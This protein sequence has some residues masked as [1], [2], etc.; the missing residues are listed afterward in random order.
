MTAMR[1][2]AYLFPAFPVLHQT[3]TLFEVVGL[4]RRGYEICLF[5]LRSA[6]GGPQQKEAEPLVAETEYCPNLLSRAMLGRFFHAVRQRPGDV[7]RLFAAVI[8]AWRERHP[9]ASDHSEAPAATTL[10]SHQRKCASDGKH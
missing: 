10:S 1:R 3:F 5:S 2:L 4:K 6:G 7:T 9:G 8:S